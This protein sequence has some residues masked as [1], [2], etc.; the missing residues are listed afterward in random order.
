LEGG[1]VVAAPTRG[2]FRE[3]SDGSEPHCWLLIE[4]G[5][6]VKEKT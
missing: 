4:W 3:N 2:S 6:Y 1:P 5:N